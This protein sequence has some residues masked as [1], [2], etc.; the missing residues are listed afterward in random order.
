MQKVVTVGELRKALERFGD[1]RKVYVLIGKETKPVSVDWSAVDP[2][3][4]VPE[5]VL[6]V[7][8]DSSR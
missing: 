6:L 4:G 3:L 5:T 7:P 8:D 1:N 2:S